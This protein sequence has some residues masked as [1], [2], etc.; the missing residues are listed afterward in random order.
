[1]ARAP[2][3]RPPERQYRM[4]VQTRPLEAHVELIHASRVAARR[5]FVYP[6]H[7]HA[8]FEIIVPVRGAYVCRI[9]GGPVRALPGRAV[10][11][12]PNDRHQDFVARGQVYCGIG[13]QISAKGFDDARLVG[14]PVAAR[15]VVAADLRDLADGLLDETVRGDHLAAR[16]QD[17]LAE[18]ALW[19]LLRAIP[20]ADL[21]GIWRQD[22]AAGSFHAEFERVLAAA[23]GKA[24]TVAQL[25]HAL[26]TSVSALQTA[27]VRHLGLP[28]AKAL[29]RWRV[30]QARRLLADPL[31]SVSDVSQR[32]GF[33]NPYH[34]ARVVRRH[35]GFPP[36]RLRQR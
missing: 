32:L 14:S 20:A 30:Q 34:F 25:A 24:L 9:N 19:R 26:R 1:M 23:G 29:S 21:A 33:A 22:A 2:R 4:R 13:L 18:E 5:P 7:R 27:C 8:S 35:T 16:R 15:R 11:V 3:P 17:S 36:S 10:V 31:L 6:E 28:P 12:Q